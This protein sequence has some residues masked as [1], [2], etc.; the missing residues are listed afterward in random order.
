MDK[1]IDNYNIELTE[2]ACHV[3]ALHYG[4]LVTLPNDIS[5]IFPYINAMGGKAIYDHS[6]RILILDEAGQKYAFRPR[7]IRIAGVGNLEDARKIAGEMVDRL[8]RLWQERDTITPDFTE[9]RP[10]PVMNIFK[11]LPGTSCGHCGYSTCMAFAA[12]LSRGAARL[13]DCPP[14]SQ[15]ESIENRDK[16]QS[17]IC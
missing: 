5:A 17:I 8:N 9:R 16:L 2:P 13:E 11:L 10:P 14:L 12:A 1:L 7:D 3:G 15:A 4:G 6:N